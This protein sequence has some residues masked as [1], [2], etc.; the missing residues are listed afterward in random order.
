MGD[1]ERLFRGYHRFL[2]VAGWALGV[3]VALLIAKL[4]G[5]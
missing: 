1:Y 3:G 4:M 5:R 2:L